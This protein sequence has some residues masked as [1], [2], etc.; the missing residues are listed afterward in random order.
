M[1]DSYVAMQ[2][3]CRLEKEKER[4]REG[5]D[6]LPLQCSAV[7]RVDYNVTLHFLTQI[8]SLFSPASQPP[9]GGPG[10]LR[11][12]NMEGRGEGREENILL[13]IVVIFPLGGT[14]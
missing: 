4:E 11:G 2:C 9:P 10:D 3:C 8:I 5:G 6:V 14:D 1:E 12:Q 13:N 7:S